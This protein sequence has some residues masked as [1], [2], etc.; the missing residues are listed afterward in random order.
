MS[1][2]SWLLDKALD[3]DVP[4]VVMLPETHRY[5]MTRVARMERFGN[6]HGVPRVLMGSTASSE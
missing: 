4:G 6:L 1:R 2:V 5:L 3:G